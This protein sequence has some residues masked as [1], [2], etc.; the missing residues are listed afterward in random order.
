[1]FTRFPILVLSGCL[2]SAVP[3]IGQEEKPRAPIK[4]RYEYRPDHDP[5]GT[6]K[7]YMNREIALVMGHEAAGWLERPEREKEERPSKLIQALK[8][9]PGQTIADIGA[10]SG[11]FAFRIAKLVGPKGKVYAVDI[12]PEMLAIIKKRIKADNVTNVVPVQGTATDPKLPANTIDLILLV[13]CYHEFSHPYEM[14]VGMVKALKPGGRIVFVEYRK[15]DPRVPIKLVHKM[16]QAQVKREMS[17]HP[18]KWIET[19]DILPWQHI[20]IFEKVQSKD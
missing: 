12:Q 17:L 3:A 4:P 18:L 2:L 20:I 8:I 14:A 1:M 10:G 5:N 7:F 15:E 9:Q 11:Y 6:G 16:S 19:L 13:D